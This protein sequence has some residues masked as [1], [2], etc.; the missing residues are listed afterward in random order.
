MIGL[1]ADDTLRMALL[2]RWLYYIWLKR[3]LQGTTRWS[4][5][6]QMRAHNSIPTRVAMR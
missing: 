5:I 3:L 1:T 6:K 2:P 4:T